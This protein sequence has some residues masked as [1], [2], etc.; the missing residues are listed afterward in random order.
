MYGRFNWS[1]W[2]DSTRG[3]AKV[4]KSSWNFSF[5]VDNDQIGIT[6]LF[7]HS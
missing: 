5:V 6:S 7:V 1:T 2:E 4:T 3:K